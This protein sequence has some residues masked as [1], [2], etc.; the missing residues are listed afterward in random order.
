M[1]C[2]ST[3]IL[4][5]LL[6]N[7]YIKGFTYQLLYPRFCLSTFLSK[8]LLINFYIKGFA[9]QLLYQSF[10]FSTFISKVFPKTLWSHL[11]LIF[12]IDV[13][14]NNAG[15]SQMASWMNVELSVDRNLFEI[16]V[17]GPV[18]LSQ[19]VI[20]YMVE[21]GGGQIVVV[22]SLAGKIGMY[23]SSLISRF[24]IIILLSFYFY[25]VLELVLFFSV[26]PRL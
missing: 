5:I 8:V 26:F 2:L 1:F 6:I 9:H 21:K 13:L 18:S 10:C 17:L 4:N 19:K 12:Q 24:H 22:S 14:V 25:Q 15:R 20:P 3:F 23:S 11:F 7:F 16:N